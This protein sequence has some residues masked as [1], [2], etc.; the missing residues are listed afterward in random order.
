MS[1][2]NKLY[3]QHGQSLWLDYVDRNL[4]VQGGLDAM[5]AE[6]LRGVT[7]NPTIFQKAVT[8]NEEYNDLIFDLTKSSP[9]IN[10]EEI[11]QWLTIQDIQMAADILERVYVESNGK[12]GYVSL[13]VSP[14]LAYEEDDT[15]NA[16]RHLWQAVDRPNLMVKVPGTVPGVAAFEQLTAEGI[17]VN[18]TLLFSTERYKDVAHA[19]LRGLSLNPNPEKIAS[20]ASFFVSRVDNKVDAALD[21]VDDP[22]AKSLG[23]RIAV[24]N[25]KVAYQIFKEVLESEEYKA[26]ASRGARPQRTL[27]AS[28]STKNPDYS[29]VLYVEELIGPNTVNTVPLETLDAFQMHGELRNSLESDVEQAYRDIE[30]LTDF[31]IDLGQITKELEQ[32]GVAK[33]SESYDQLLKSL[34]EQR[35]AVLAEKA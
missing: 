33:F 34:E 23:G 32:E 30:A 1:K 22:K 17:N 2:I 28:T 4:L 12:D 15:I 3:T 11:Y 35:E 7:S 21:K 8:D 20:V 25:A 9:D 16:A 31:G 18:V 6:G 24:A 10:A 29:D 13:E 5:V 27:W 19:Y 14:H 26:Q